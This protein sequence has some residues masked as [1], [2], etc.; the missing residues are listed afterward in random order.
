MTTE[1]EYMLADFNRELARIGTAMIIDGAEVRAFI[2]PA[3]EAEFAGGR[4][5]ADG[6]AVEA[7]YLFVNPADLAYLPKEGGAMVVE[8]VEYR[9]RLVDTLGVACKIM[10]VRHL[11]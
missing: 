7:K 2:R 8:N 1:R 6:L 10:L 5:A 11:S 4:F 3:T 9:V